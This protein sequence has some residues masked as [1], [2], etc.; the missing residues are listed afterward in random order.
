MN[1]FFFERLNGFGRKTAIIVVCLMLFIAIVVTIALLIIN[2]TA[3]AD[4]YTIS[5]DSITSIKAVIGKRSITSYTSNIGG[6]L[7]E[8]KYEYNNVT[9]VKEDIFRYV[10]YLCETDGFRILSSVDFTQPKG[11]V[12]L[13]KNSIDKKK[14]ILITIE[15]SLSNYTITIEKGNA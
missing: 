8:K 12:L 13:E 14:V 3:N 4:C 15:Y 11:R 6:G 2:K 10:D 7:E 5:G 1:G 9:D